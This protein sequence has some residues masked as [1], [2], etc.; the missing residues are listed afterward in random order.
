M[1]LVNPNA[2]VETGLNIGKSL[3]ECLFLFTAPQKR[4]Q[5]GQRQ[6][7]MSNWQILMTKNGI[8]FLYVLN[9][10]FVLLDLSR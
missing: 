3:P 5:E 9:T 10:T 1:V 2:N 8:S 6:E 7:P 4:V